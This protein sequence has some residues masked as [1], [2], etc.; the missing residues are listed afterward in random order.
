[1]AANPTYGQLLALKGQGFIANGI[2][3]ASS[4]NLAAIQLWNPTGSG[5]ILLLRN[6]VISVGAACFVQFGQNTTE[7]A[8]ALG[9]GLNKLIGGAI[10]VGLI[11]GSNTAGGP[12]L[13][14]IFGE[15]AIPSATALQLPFVDPIIVTA[16]NGLALVSQ[17]ANVEMSAY[18]EWDE[19]NG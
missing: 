8:A 12:T 6:C 14:G 17:I 18:F 4:G 15:P 1:M 19:V 7:L 2:L 11:R 9:Q 16:G 3:A 13:G 5:K 10:G